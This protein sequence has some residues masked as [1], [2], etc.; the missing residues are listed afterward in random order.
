[1]LDD[2][3]D[4]FDG[5]ARLVDRLAD[6]LHIGDD[7]GDFAAVGLPPV[8]RI[9]LWQKHVGRVDIFAI[10]DERPAHHDG[11]CLK[12]QMIG[13][14]KFAEPVAQRDGLGIGVRCGI[15]GEIPGENTVV[16]FC[17]RDERIEI[18]ILFV[19]RDRQREHLKAVL[20]G[21]IE[22]L[23]VFIERIGAGAVDEIETRRL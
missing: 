8:D 22:K 3:P 7:F 14:K 4:A 1:M 20:V 17:L 11:V 19:G 13:I 2:R 18:E 9:K 16:M 21:E 23:F 15:I 5:S 6:H 12:R 10:A